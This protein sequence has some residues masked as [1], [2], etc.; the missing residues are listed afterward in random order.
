MGESQAFLQQRDIDPKKKNSSI[1]KDS[2]LESCF[3]NVT[4]KDK[5]PSGT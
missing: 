1:L 3:E 5:I 4:Q 2:I